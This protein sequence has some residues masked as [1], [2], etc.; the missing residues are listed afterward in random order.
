METEP[1]LRVPEI[2]RILKLT[3]EAVRGLI[4]SGIL[5]GYKIG[6]AARNSAYSVPL[7][8]VLSLKERIK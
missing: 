5:P 6:A 7:S 2:A 1:R 4:N 3:P 8:A